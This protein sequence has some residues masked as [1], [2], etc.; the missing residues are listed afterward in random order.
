MD[1]KEDKR[2]FADTKPHGVH[3]WGSLLFNIFTEWSNLIHKQYKIEID[4]D[5][6]LM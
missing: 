2:K 4:L 6:I 3:P 1:K 5:A